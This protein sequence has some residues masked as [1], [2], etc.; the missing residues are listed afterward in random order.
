MS[1]TLRNTPPAWS[2]QVPAVADRFQV[3]LG[4][5]AVLD[6]ET[7]L[8]WERSPATVTRN[9]ASAVTT[10]A[11]NS[12]GGRFGWRLPTLAEL[13]SLAPLPAGHPFAPTAMGLPFWTLTSPPD[14][15]TRAWT[16]S[17]DVGLVDFGS[18][19]KSD[20]MNYRRWCVRSG[21]PGSP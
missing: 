21:H 18:P 6:R 10:C 20:T 8:V 17:H 1:L 11:I 14:D 16:V 3:V 2:Y 13:A 4:G 9:W 5:N 19:T 12:F 7:G 15:A